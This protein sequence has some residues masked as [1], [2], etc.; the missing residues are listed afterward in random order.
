MSHDY[1]PD[2]PNEELMR[3]D[4]KLDDPNMILSALRDKLGDQN[5]EEAR[6]LCRDMAIGDLPYNKLTPAEKLLCHRVESTLLPLFTEEAISQWT[7]LVGSDEV[8]AK[9]TSKK[10]PFEVSNAMT[11][12]THVNF[13]EELPALFKIRKEGATNLDGDGYETFM[14]KGKVCILASEGGVGKS[15]LCLHLGISLA[16]SEHFERRGSGRG[17]F[18]SKTRLKNSA[19][20]LLTPN[21]TTGKVVMLFAEEDHQTCSLRLRKLLPKE[22]MPDGS[23]QVSEALLRGLS[24]RLIPFPLS[25]SGNSITLSTSGRF[26]FA[27]PEDDPANE[28]VEALIDNLNK[29][30]G[31][32]GLD[33]IVLDPLAQFGGADFEKDNGAASTLMS[34]IEKLTIRV[35]GKPSVLVVHHSPKNSNG[36]VRGSSALSDNS[37]WVGLLSRVYDLAPQKATGQKSTNSKE[38]STQLIDKDGRGVL[39]LRVHKSNYSRT[40]I[41]LR[42][43]TQGPEIIEIDDDVVLTAE[44]QAQI[45]PSSNG[46]GT[47]G[48]NGNNENQPRRRSY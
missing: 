45:T 12:L 7:A 1:K 33:L 10:S 17:G 44:T 11:D 5:A 46:G 27:D 47:N 6:R 48:S 2:D 34:Q 40:G 13:A 29:L 16:T 39:E 43:V 36:G 15:L 18:T 41:K 22:R 14:P 20:H 8:E 9:A 28:R 21:P 32:D 4:Y 38:P 25:G 23:Y 24:G 35:K 19:G 30:A 31:D 37:R 42:Y 26:S 3:H